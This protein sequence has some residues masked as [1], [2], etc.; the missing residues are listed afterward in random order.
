MRLKSLEY[1]EHQGEPEEWTLDGLTLGDVNL[2][3][4]KNASGKSRIL[5]VI[6][7][8]ARGITGKRQLHNG[9]FTLIF[10]G[11]GKES[12]YELNIRDK[13][14]VSERFT[15]DNDAKLE[16][17]E[18]G[19]GTIFAVKEGKPVEFQ[20]PEDQLA[21]VARRDT[22]Q[23]PFFEPLYEWAGSLY[24]YAFGTSLGRE[25]LTFFVDGGPVADAK[26]SSHVVAIF[27]RGMEDFGDNFENAVREDFSAIGYPIDEIGLV[28]PRG[29]KVLRSFAGEPTV[30]FVKESDL[31]AKT[32]QHSMSQ[33][34]FR[35]LSIIVQINYS[36]LADTPSCFLVDD[37]G[38]GLDFDRSCA[39]IDFLMKKAEGSSV[40][41]V[42]ATND[43]FTMNRV[44]LE[45]WSVIHR[46]GNHVNILNYTNSK[47]VFDKFKFT[48][49]NNFDF[50]AFDYLHAG[51]T[52]E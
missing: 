13:E 31:P 12:K 23:H 32:Y 19:E 45:D 30:I 42:M 44:P 43:R 18:G 22:I 14:I 7:N 5:N 38:E 9:H 48:G 49:L 24:H 52:D 51:T 25:S 17:G 41:L 21:V 34:M 29:I 2:L 3:V 46:Q 8:L 1:T 20:T 10:E 11:D 35:A 6:H 27:R 37:I 33:G 50:L 16:R 36:V 47:E 4:G 28:A 40:Q 26:D 39:L 15:V